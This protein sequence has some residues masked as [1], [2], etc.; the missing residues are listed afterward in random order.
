[1]DTKSKQ[2][3]QKSSV[4]PC[5]QGCG[6]SL[7]DR[8]QHDACPVCLEIVHAMRALMEPKPVILSLAPAL[9]AG[10]T[11]DVCGESAGTYGCRTP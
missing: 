11:G 5:P 8:D 10:K 2:A 9:E 4:C 6:F 7:H 1:M 3:G